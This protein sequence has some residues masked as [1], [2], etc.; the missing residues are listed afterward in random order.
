MKKSCDMKSK[1]EEAILGTGS[2]RS[3]LMMRRR[4]TSQS[5]YQGMYLDHFSTMEYAEGTLAKGNSSA[6]LQPVT[7]LAF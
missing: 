7:S 1:L 5:L 4:N 6:P 3:D 2:A